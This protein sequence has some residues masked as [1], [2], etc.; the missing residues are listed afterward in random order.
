MYLHTRDTNICAHTSKHNSHKALLSLLLSF[1]SKSF[2]GYSN[3][4]ALRH[5]FLFIAPDIMLCLQWV[6]HQDMFTSLWPQCFKMVHILTLGTM[7][8]LTWHAQAHQIDK[9]KSEFLTTA[10][11]HIYDQ[12][13]AWL[14]L[15]NRP[16][17][18]P[19]SLESLG[20]FLFISQSS[21]GST[22]L[23]VAANEYTQ[24]NK[25]SAYPK[26]KRKRKRRYEG[27]I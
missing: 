21:E 24:D 6:F 17:T 23:F 12:P 25:E 27:L 7:T 1:A 2:Q 11:R 14:D 10:L 5:L 4:L 16:G 8:Q 9:E 20:P 22:D 19:G 18:L 13:E 15:Y 26:E 3:L